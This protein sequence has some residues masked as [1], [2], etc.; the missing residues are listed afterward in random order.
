MMAEP[1][2]KSV[3]DV[4]GTVGQ[5]LLNTE[6]DDLIIELIQN[7]LDARSSRTLIQVLDDR[8]VCEGDGWPIKDDGWKRL[9]LI[10]GAGGEVT[11][12]RDGIG[13][14]NHG[15]RVGF[16]IGDTIHV[17]S[18]GRRT[19]LTTR[20]DSSKTRFFPG[21]WEQAVADPT[22]PTIGTRVS[23]LYR[24][25]ELSAAG[26]EGL[27][28]PT[29]D[30]ATADRLLAG[31]LAAAPYRLIGVTHPTE[32]PRFT[33]DLIPSNGTT[34]QFIFSCRKVGGADGFPLL[35]RTVERRDDGG[36]IKLIA[37]ERA[38][39]FPIRGLR[40]KAKV[41][42]FFKG[43]RGI[44]AEISWEVGPNGKPRSAQGALRYPITYLPDAGAVTDYGMH[45]SAPFV[46]NQARHAPASGGETNTE[47]IKRGEEFTAR[48]L[49]RY[50]VPKF[51]P[52]VLALIRSAG[53]STPQTE[54]LIEAVG[55]GRG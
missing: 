40:R 48:I 32:L 1:E 35:E 24:R 19:Q 46:S 21:A 31:M 6:P 27:D 4:P 18:N 17:Q 20:R 33:L 22:A 50:L 25:E 51:G 41:S 45:L 14:K 13:A 39:R 37:K 34:V 36:T 7:D 55:R 38:I 29:A 30:G 15:L 10:L 23:I 12:K 49:S 9:K 47:I 5:F 28:L 44:E 3:V 16:W 11:P 52:S 26:V 53:L 2:Y 8:L 42:W 43:T 54:G